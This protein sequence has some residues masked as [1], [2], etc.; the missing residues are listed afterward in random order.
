[1]DTALLLEYSVTLSL[2]ESYNRICLSAIDSPVSGAYWKIE[3][4][5]GESFLDELP[6][7]QL[8]PGQLY[9]GLN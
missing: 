3:E 7:L 9:C 8:N 1:M 4:M 5:T 6:L 2:A